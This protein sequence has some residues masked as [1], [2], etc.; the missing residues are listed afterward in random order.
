[1]PYH[2]GMMGNTSTILPSSLERLSRTRWLHSA[3]HHAN[4]SAEDNTTQQNA[5]PVCAQQAR[6]L[7]T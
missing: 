7:P 5:T 6:T 3:L 1:M 2:R 4:N